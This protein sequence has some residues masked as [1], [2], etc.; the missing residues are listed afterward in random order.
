MSL[1]TKSE[2]AATVKAVSLAT[3]LDEDWLMLRWKSGKDPFQRFLRQRD[4][5]IVAQS[6]SPF[7][8]EAKDLYLKSKSKGRPETFFRS[9]ERSVNYLIGMHGDKPIDTYSRMEAND[10]RDAFA[11]RGLTSASIQRNFAVL[12]AIVNFATKELGIPEIRS[13]S[14]VYMGSNVDDTVRKRLP[15]PKHVLSELQSQCVQMDDEA[16]W[17]IALLSDTGMRLGEAVG[18]VKS[19]IHLNG[20]HPFIRL[21]EHPWRRLKTAGSARDV[22]L[23]GMALWSVQRSIKASNT[24]CLFPKYCSKNACKVNSA[25][26]ALNKWMRPRVPNGCVVH[27]FRH[28]MRDRLRAVE[29]PSDII[30]RIGGWSVEGVGETY[31]S[32]YPIKVLHNWMKKMVQP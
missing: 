5:I 17:L 20:D 4:S 11:E 18:L 30:D 28:T 9:V 15:F 29:C 32:G 27:S 16:R 19:D 14:S 6:S 3:R 8:S 26:G 24:D 7:M 13:F 23:V 21:V 31:G 22:P 12:R 25:S 10:L 1:R 2:K